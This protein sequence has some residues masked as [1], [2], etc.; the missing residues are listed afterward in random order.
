MLTFHPL[1]SKG[2]RPATIGFTLDA[3]PVSILAWIGEKFITWTDETPSLDAILDSIT[4]YWLYVTFRVTLNKPAFF[5]SFCN[6]KTSL[7]FF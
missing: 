3:S 4:L 7:E 2:T 6:A 5:S 1:E